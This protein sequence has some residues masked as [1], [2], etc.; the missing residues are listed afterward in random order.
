MIFFKILPPAL[1]NPFP[2]NK[3]SNNEA[4]KVPNNIDK[5]PPFYSLLSFLIV[6]ITP[7]NKTPE[8]SRLLIIFIMSFISSFEI[9]KVVVFGVD[10]EPSTFFW[11]TS[12]NC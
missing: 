1:K 9:I 6:L 2:D 8:S 12:I 7:F 4:P 11:N 5:K 10:P 3:F